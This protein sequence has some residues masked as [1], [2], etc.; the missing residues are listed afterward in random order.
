MAKKQVPRIDLNDQLGTLLL[1]AASAPSIINYEPHKKQLAFHGMDRQTRLYIGGNRSGK[2][3]GGVVEDIW[4]ATGKHPYIETPP[5]PVRGR[6]IAVDYIQGIEQIILPLFAQWLPLSEL[7]NGSWEDSYSK[8]DRVLTLANGSTIEFMGYEQ[9]LE[10]FAGTSRHFVHF[11]EEPPKSIYI[12]N[13]ARVVDTGGRVWLTMTPVEGMTW[14]YDDIYERAKKK[15]DPNIGVIE[16]DMTENPYLSPGEINRFLGLLDQDEQDARIHGTFVQIGGLVYKK[17]QQEI[18]VI[19]PSKPPLDWEWYLSIDHGY[20]NPT[21][22]LWHAVSPTGYVMTFHE[23]YQS[24]MTVAQHAAYINAMTVAFGRPVDVTVG[25]P[26]MAQ[27]NGATGT[28]IFEEYAKHGIYIVPGGNEVQAGVAKIQGYLAQKQW[29]ITEDCPNLISEMQRLRWKT[30]QNKRTAEKY[31]KHEVIEKKNDHACDSARYFFSMVPDLSY[32]P[33]SPASAQNR[34]TLAMPEAVP[35][36]TDRDWQL[37][38]PQYPNQ[39]VSA[40]D[41]YVGGIW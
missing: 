22:C 12:E 31:N 5:P 10:K 27:R 14:V 28:S 33:Q 21:A 29:Q 38:A 37:S 25:D 8:G 3:V 16:V 18:H 7:T 9:K 2:S 30:W 15:K 17:F 4:W 26:A 19:K 11:D 20:N 36:A 32:D 35:Y 6:V 1:R 24:E 41:E 39:E 23:H 40:I 13:Q 34:D